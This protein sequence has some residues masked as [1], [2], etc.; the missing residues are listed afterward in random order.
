MNIDELLQ[1]AVN[2][3]QAGELQQA[4]RLYRD[5]LQIRPD[6]P[7][8]NYNLGLLAMQLEQPA[9]G[10]PYLQNAW[11]LNPN[12]EQF[13]LTLMKCL[14][15]LDRASDALQIFKNARQGNGFNSVQAAPLLLLATSIVEGDRPAISIEMEV[16][17][18]FK[19][20]NHALLEARLTDLLDQYPNWGSGWDTLCTTLRIQGKDCERA[21][22][23]ALQLKPDNVG[24]PRKIFCIGANKT[25]TTSLK[26]AFSSLGL[27]VGDQGIAEL[28]V[29]DWAQQDYRRIIKYC[30]S[31]EAFQDAPFSC[32]DT[33]Q[34]MDEAFPGSKFILTVRNNADEWYESL[35]RF[36][37]KI[38][39]K[40][41]IPT[42][43]DLRQFNYRFPGFVLNGL[44]LVFGADESEPYSRERYIQWYEEH[45]NK[46]K[47]YF[48]GR[49]DDLLVLN[50]AET[51]AM[52]RLLVFLGYPYTGQKMPHLN[53]SKG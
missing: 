47:Q 50:V 24:S 52:E 34:A 32:D 10:M 33:F 18:L 11:K 29:F 17:A 22:Q 39:G 15:I 25:G 38:V 53:S 3:H 8:V 1:Q 41:R 20:G 43:D 9:S 12:I 6:L 35:V 48:K 44:K 23:R 4:E 5:I 46:I 28:L 31:A 26:N 13:G 30:R 36:H 45:N 51:D 2:C 42:A 37:S 40:G 19:E 14:L 27:T 49:P 16:S 7:D 21:L